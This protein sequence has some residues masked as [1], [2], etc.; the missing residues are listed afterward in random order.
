VSEIVDRVWSTRDD[1]YSE[2][3]S[4]QTVSIGSR[5]EMSYIGG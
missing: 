3:R 1:R 2:I 5:V 4:S